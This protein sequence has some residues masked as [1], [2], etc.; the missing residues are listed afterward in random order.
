MIWV[1]L[2]GW[3]DVGRHRD[4]NE[5]RLFYQVQQSSDA[6][7]V[8][9]CIV[10]D[11]VGGHLGGKVA[12]HWTV[13]TIKRE[14]ADLFLPT[15]PR[16][17]LH[18]TPT[19]MHALR[20]DQ[21]TGDPADALAISRIRTAIENANTTVRE[22]ALHRPDE[23]RDAG[24]TVTLVLLKNTRAYVANVGDSRAYLLRD[25]QMAPITR[26]HS[27]VAEL[28]AAGRITAEQALDHPQANL[29]TRC[30]GHREQ[31]E[32]DIAAHDLRPG[33]SLLLCSDGLWDALRDP[34]LIA[35]IIL[36]TP[37]LETVAHRLVE[38]ANHSGGRDNIAVAL[39]RVT[40]REEIPF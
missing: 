37:D 35:R 2:A 1:E 15:D 38:A 24:S 4:V 21:G 39:L 6:P 13:E 17:T 14:L 28:V 19:E 8:A 9:M 40:E 36:S 7:P 27:V 18:L 29:I 22:Y 16:A 30:L 11:G 33:D 20:S 12:S 25:N 5:D 10:A 31:V 34:V 32:V 26:D 23:A 3:S